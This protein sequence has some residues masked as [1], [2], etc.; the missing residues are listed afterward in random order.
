MYVCMHTHIYIHSVC[1]C[2]Y[3]FIYMYIYFVCMYIHVW[4]CQ[5]VHVYTRVSVY[6]CACMCT[7]GVPWD[8]VGSHSGF[9]A[10]EPDRPSACS[11]CLPL[12]RLVLPRPCRSWEEACDRRPRISILPPATRPSWWKLLVL[13]GSHTAVAPCSCRCRI[14]TSIHHPA[15][16]VWPM[17]MGL[18][19]RL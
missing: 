19:E 15:I 9:T 18:L 8:R 1:V 7:L 5:F 3:S 11:L 16:Y 2:V 14:K 4:I 6:V 12:S 10:G 17:I 13:T